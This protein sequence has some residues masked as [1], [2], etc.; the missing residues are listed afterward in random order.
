LIAPNFAVS[1]TG[2]DRC[3]VVHVVGELDCSTASLLRDAVHRLLGSFDASPAFPS[4]IEFDLA[5]LTFCG[6][7]GARLLVDLSDALRVAGIPVSCANPRPLLR[8]LFEILGVDH[9][10]DRV[11]LAV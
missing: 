5:E 6:S 7:A 3:V 9:D 10:L 11:P 4:R 1:F 8:R 2:R